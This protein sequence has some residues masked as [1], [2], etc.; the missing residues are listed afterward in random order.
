MTIE[1]QISRLS[2]S[3]ALDNVRNARIE[4]AAGGLAIYRGAL[5]GADVLHRVH[6]EGTEDFVVF[7][8]RPLREE[9]NY[10]VDVSRSPGLRLVSNTLEFLD[11]AGTPLVRVAPPYVVDARGTRRDAKLAVTGCAY[12]TSSVE[13][14]GRSITR[15]GAERCSL[16]VTWTGTTTY[17]AIVDPAWSATGSMAT[18]RVFHAASVLTSG[19]VL[20]AGGSDAAYSRLAS[21]EIFDAGGNSGPGT[22]AA[23]GSMTTARGSLTASRLVSGMV[24]VAGGGATGSAAS[25]DLFN[26]VGGTFAATGSMTTERASHSAI[27]LGSGKVLVVG[28]NQLSLAGG[29]SSTAELFDPAGNGGA[30]AFAAAGTLASLHDSTQSATLLASGRVL[31]YSGG[32]AE[33]FDPAGNAGAG[34]FTVSGPPVAGHLSHTASLLPSGKVLIAGG[35]GGGFA[36]LFDPAGNGGAGTFAATVAM[37]TERSYHTA[38]V[39]PS[40]KILLV[41]GDGTGTA[42]VFDAA[43]NGGAGAFVATALPIANHYSH[44]ATVLPSGKVVVIGGGNGPA[45]GPFASAEIF[46]QAIGD[47]CTA[48]GACLS[49]H[50]ADGVCC[51]TACSGGGCDRC[52]LTGTRGTCT[53]APMGNAGANAPCAPSYAC[54]GVSVTCPTSCVS[55]AACADAYYCASSGACE[56]RKAQAST[57]NPQKDCKAAGCRECTSAACVDGLCCDKACNGTCE[58]CTAALKQS[59]VADGTCGPIKDGIDPRSECDSSGVL[60][61]ADG[62]CNGTGAC[63]LA[64]PT[65]VSCSSDG[66]VCDGLGAC[67]VPPATCDG[68]HIARKADGTTE[69]CTPYKCDSNGTC[70]SAPPAGVG[71]S[72]ID[73]CVAPSQCDPTGKCIAPA[74]ENSGGCSASPFAPPL[75]SPSV[76]FLAGAVA[77]VCQL[78]RRARGKGRS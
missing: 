60:C 52:D 49:G 8:T 59:G 38:S 39:L 4:L 69:D 27:V 50:C 62:Q 28:G 71:C 55:D 32:V 37:T 72:S 23:T 5:D 75:P 13:P 34:A 11:E 7:E 67:T 29:I 12:D 74:P 19:R 78:R 51:N 76:A 65:G 20:V 3:F 2:V 9:L 24:L 31:I 30:G 41:G 42:E 46:G 26:P 53:V 25:A 64:T 54:D 47:P 43:A 15:P 56:P 35:A 63:R 17:P 66:K 44:T 45:S 70:R 58:A 61:G 18:A 21:A 10:T 40:G 1:D 33:L 36:E 73:D 68:D 57:C 16:Q 22:F 14:W 6:G 48:D 77:L